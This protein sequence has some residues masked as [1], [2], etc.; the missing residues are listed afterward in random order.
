MRNLIEGIMSLD[1][2]LYESIIVLV[3]R[4]RIGPAI[5]LRLSF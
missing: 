4:D 5:L 2:F 1:R 3:K